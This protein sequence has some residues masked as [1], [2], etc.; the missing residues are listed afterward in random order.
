MVVLNSCN[1]QLV[2]RLVEDFDADVTMTFT[3]MRFNMLFLSVC[4]NHFDE[5][6]VEYI[7]DKMHRAH[8]NKTASGLSVVCGRYGMSTMT[9]LLIR[10]MWWITK[11]P[12][13]VGQFLTDAFYRSG[14][15]HAAVSNSVFPL[16]PFPDG[17]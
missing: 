14:L 10:C 8:S 2:R 16:N 1:Y 11:K 15:L 5:E 3:P 6:L 17:N 4:L 7:H 12:K 13:F 9:Y